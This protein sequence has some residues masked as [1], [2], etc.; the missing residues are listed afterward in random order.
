[1]K[2]FAELKW[3]TGVYDAHLEEFSQISARK[4]VLEKNHEKYTLSNPKNVAI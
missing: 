2:I 3:I 4:N 1:M